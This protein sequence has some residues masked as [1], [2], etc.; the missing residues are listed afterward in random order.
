M[1]SRVDALTAWKVSIEEAAGKESC[2]RAKD[3]IQFAADWLEMA[4]ETIQ[5]DEREQARQL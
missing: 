1:R 3:Q 5:E 4:I 2:T